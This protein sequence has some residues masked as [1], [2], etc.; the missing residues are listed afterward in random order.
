MQGQAPRHCRRDPSLLHKMHLTPR[1]VSPPPVWPGS[2][3]VMPQAGEA[4]DDEGAPR[5]CCTG[6]R[7][8]LGTLS[9]PGLGALHLG[10]PKLQACTGPHCARM[11]GG[12]E[13]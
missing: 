2:P 3:G 1:R 12:I 6:P 10:K 11:V 7:L 5:G 8:C 9:L 13:R 4:Q